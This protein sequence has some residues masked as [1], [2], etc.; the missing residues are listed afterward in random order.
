MTR[1]ASSQLTA[2]PAR[3]TYRAEGGGAD[4]RLARF[5]SVCALIQSARTRPPSSSTF[6]PSRIASTFNSRCRSG[7]SFTKNRFSSSSVFAMPHHDGIGTVIYAN[8]NNVLTAYDSSVYN[9]QSSATRAA[10]K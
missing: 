4:Q 5:G 9:G 6:V 2:A 7:A 10:V 3:E 8:A 1:A